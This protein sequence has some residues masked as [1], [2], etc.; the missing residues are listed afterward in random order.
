MSGDT[1]YGYQME[2]FFDIDTP[3]DLR[4]AD[5]ALSLLLK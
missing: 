5:E 4:L 3:Q 1:I 2:D